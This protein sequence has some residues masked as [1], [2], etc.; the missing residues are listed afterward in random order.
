MN[1]PQI[2]SFI[3]D[4]CTDLY[5][6]PPTSSERRF[7]YK[8]LR[9]YGFTGRRFETDLDGLIEAF[10]EFED[11]DDT[12][13]FD[14]FC[15]RLISYLD[16]YGLYQYQT[17]TRPTCCRYTRFL[18][19]FQQMVETSPADQMLCLS[20]QLWYMFQCSGFFTDQPRYE[21]FLEII[22][23][24]IVINPEVIGVLTLALNESGMVKPTLTHKIRLRLKPEFRK[25]KPKP[26]TYFDYLDE[27]C[28]QTIYKEVY[29]NVLREFRQK[30]VMLQEVCEVSFL[31]DCEFHE[32]RDQCSWKHIYQ[33]TVLLCKNGVCQKTCYLNTDVLITIEL[34][35]DHPKSYIRHG[36]EPVFQWFQK[37]IE[38]DEIIPKSDFYG[39][40]S[41]FFVT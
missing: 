38:P 24:Y 36:K 18:E 3:K 15:S 33:S 2:S 1:N 31:G 35:L 14:P 21:R 4:W 40:L 37:S 32:K 34:G 41:T 17:R 22:G 13:M 39:D 7:Y 12:E 26:K 9:V 29:N 11:V 10:S 27:Y 28:R 25:H 5:E 16:K 23:Q 6:R 19:K 20:D 8:T 30:Y